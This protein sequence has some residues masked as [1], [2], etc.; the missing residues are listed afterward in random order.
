[1]KGGRCVQHRIVSHAQVAPEPDDQPEDHLRSDRAQGDRRLQSS[2][3]RGDNALKWQSY[4]GDF[5]LY[6]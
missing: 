5:L 3:K 6:R 4:R 1:M 2:A